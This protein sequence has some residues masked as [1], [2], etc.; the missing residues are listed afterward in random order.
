MVAWELLELIELKIAK[1]SRRQLQV[2]TIFRDFNGLVIRTGQNNVL[3]LCIL[4][5]SVN[6]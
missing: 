3:F 5:V 1:L 6:V 2:K 4:I